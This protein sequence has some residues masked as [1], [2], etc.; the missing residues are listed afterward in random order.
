MF[1][2]HPLEQLA[3]LCPLSARIR[4]QIDTFTQWLLNADSPGSRGLSQA[5][6]NQRFVD[7]TGAILT[8]PAHPKFLVSY[9][10]AGKSYRF[11]AVNIVVDR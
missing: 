5:T 4:L 7:D 10:S 6:I 9:W 1:P 2:N 8:D 3:A 11:D